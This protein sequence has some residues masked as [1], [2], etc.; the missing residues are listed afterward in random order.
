MTTEAEYRAIVRRLTRK[1]VAGQP[2]FNTPLDNVAAA[3]IESLLAENAELRKALRHYGQHEYICNSEHGR[4]KN[5]C[6][7]GFHALCQGEKP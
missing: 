5:R 7:C 6:D 3:A 1:T 2:V 4:Y